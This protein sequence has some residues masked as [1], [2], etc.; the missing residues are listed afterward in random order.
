M[1]EELPRPILD[2]QELYVPIALLPA[3]QLDR[4]Q[5]FTRVGAAMD[6]I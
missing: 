1:K 5:F 3:T 2:A 4:I 6:W